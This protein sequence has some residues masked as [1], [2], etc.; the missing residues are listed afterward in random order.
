M[1]IERRPLTWDD[2]ESLLSPSSFPSASS[3][4][5]KYQSCSVWGSGVSRLLQELCESPKELPNPG[6]SDRFDLANRMSNYFCSIRGLVSSPLST[7]GLSGSSITEFMLSNR[8]YVIADAKTNNK[9]PIVLENTI[10]GSDM[11]IS[12]FL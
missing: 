12:G 5:T 11:E 4:R 7:I 8:A 10:P 2:G 1:R 6:L 9:I 3:S